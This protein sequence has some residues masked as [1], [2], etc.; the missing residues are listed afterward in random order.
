M[1]DSQGVRPLEEKVKVIKDFCQ[2]ATRPEL[3]KFLGLINFYHR[4]IPNCAQILQPL[5]ALLP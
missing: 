2:P 5:N 3:H 4:F 1:P